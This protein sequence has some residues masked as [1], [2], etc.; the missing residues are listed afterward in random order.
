MHAINIKRIELV[1]RPTAGIDAEGSSG[2]YN[3]VLK[4]TIES[5]PMVH[6]QSTCACDIA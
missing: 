4:S 5:S 3:I 2:Y 1:T 6:M